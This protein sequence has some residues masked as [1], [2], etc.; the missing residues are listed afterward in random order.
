[1]CK[2]FIFLFIYSSLYYF[3]LYLSFILVI[4]ASYFCQIIVTFSTYLAPTTN[5][6]IGT[7][8]KISCKLWQTTAIIATLS[9]LPMYSYSSSDETPQHWYK[10]GQ[11]SLK[12]A[13]R[14]QPNFRHA[15]NIILFV[16]D[17]MGISTVTAARIFE[18]Q[19][20]G[21]NGEENNLSFE[22][23][24]YL[25]MAKTYNTNQQTP[26]SAGTM[27]AMMSGIKTK[28]GVIGVNQNVV[29][30]D[31]ESLAGNEVTSFLDMAERA[32]LSTG[33]VSTARITHATPAATYAHS[34]ERNWEDW[35]DMPEQAQA[36]GCKDIADQL[37]SYDEGDGIDV[38]LG[39][40]RRHFL[41]K[42]VAYNIEKPV[43][44]GAEGDRTD[45]RDLTKEWQQRYPE[46][47]F[48]VDQA[49]F[50]AIESHHT[51][52]LFGL[53]NES[54]MAYENDRSDDTLGE[55]SLSAMTEKAIAILNNNRKGFFLTVE[56]GRIDHGH[57]A[58]SAHYA[59]A[60]TVEF[61]KAVRSAMENTDPNETLIIVTADHSHVFTIAGYPTRGN[62]ILGKVVGNDA[63]G[64]AK[65]EPS[66][67]RDDMPYTTLGYM[68]GR[69]VAEYAP[70]DQR[71]EL[72]AETG[73]SVDLTDVDTEHKGFHQEAL[74][75]LS[76]E[77]HS[78]EDVAIYAG[79]PWAHL[80]KKTQEQN[81]IFH[82]MQHAASLNSRMRNNKRHWKYWY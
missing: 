15:K 22:E 53:F 46:G 76:S 5:V 13:L 7:N 61:A 59:L 69:G 64:N 57:H 60:D 2:I 18:G 56:S 9:T 6:L 36:A 51:N 43:A 33:I 14:Q 4:K 28:A 3:Y 32:G 41:P 25:A 71:Y 79:G 39:G 38:I 77:T 70:G 23:L 65:K 62:P 82:V 49:G 27:T 1:M 72:P 19:L 58:G 44:D 80:F 16:G 40:G 66:L 67:A 24:P 8:M 37:V 81:Y 20:R 26:D 29:R 31:C 47:R 73:R 74:V 50:D 63:S 11:K 42:D 54:H 52:K 68:N 55:P 30:G 35:S 34:P 10:E 12:Q 21:E 48:I 17:G 75:P 78:G 45:G